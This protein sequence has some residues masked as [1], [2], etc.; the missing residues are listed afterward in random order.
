MDRVDTVESPTAR[1][2][3]YDRDPPFSPEA[4]VSVLGGML[5]DTDAVDRAA[6]VVND[7]MF[8]REA[9]DLPLHASSRGAT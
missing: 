6:E 3:G 5:I 9:A 8:F 4:E 2:P 1:S 7:S